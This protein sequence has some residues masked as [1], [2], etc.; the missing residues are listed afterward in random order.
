MSRSRNIEFRGPFRKPDRSDKEFAVWYGPGGEDGDSATEVEMSDPSYGGGPISVSEYESLVGY[1]D[2]V[3]EDRPFRKITTTFDVAELRAAIK[4]YR[5]NKLGGADIKRWAAG[6]GS[7]VI[8]HY[9]GD[10]ET[11]DSLP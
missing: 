11:V 1:V 5:G 8:A 9:G 10:E 4:A 2:D 3:D 7:A 6:Y